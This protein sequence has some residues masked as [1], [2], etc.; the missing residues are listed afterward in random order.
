VLL[1]L[2][3]NLR[4][5]RI[6]ATRDFGE[7]WA[8]ISKLDDLESAARVFSTPD[9]LFIQDTVATASRRSKLFSIEGSL[10]EDNL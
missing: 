9:N 1:R 4:G 2:K 5:V 10:I 7:S 8:T 6:D 3:S